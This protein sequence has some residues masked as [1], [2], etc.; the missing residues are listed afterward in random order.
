MMWTPEN[1]TWT[2]YDRN[3][4]KSDLIM[5]IKILWLLGLSQFDLQEIKHHLTNHVTDT[6]KRIG[7]LQKSM[8]KVIDWIDKQ[9]S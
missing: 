9:P 5:A 4:E 6:D 2:K 7:D 1:L 8:A 3:Q